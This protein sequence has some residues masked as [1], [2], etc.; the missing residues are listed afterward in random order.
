MDSVGR[1]AGGVAHETNNQMS[2]VLGAAHFLL[3]RQDLDES[4]RADLEHI[5]QA[6]DRTAQITAQLLAFSRRQLLRPVSLDLGDAVRQWENVLRR[7]AGENCRVAL[8]LAAGMGRVRVDLG[9]LHQVLLNLVLNARDAMPEGGTVTIETFETEL[10]AETTNRH[11]ST[12]IRPGPYGVIA[13]SDSGVGMSPAVLERIFEP[14]FTTKPVGAGTGLGLATVYGIVKQSEG[15]IW[16]YSEPGLGS[17]LKVYLPLESA[18]VTAE[19]PVA[20]A[21]A[22]GR[23]ELVVVIEDDEM[24]RAMTRRALEGAGY[25]VAEASGGEGGI[26]AV[27]RWGSRTGAV[28]SDLVMPGLTA[29]ALAERIEAIS[30]GTPVLFTSGY[31]DGE[32]ERRGLLPAGAPFLQKPSSP[33]A[34]VAFVGRHVRVRAGA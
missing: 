32:I 7:V 31:T 8:R 9:Q 17:T 28:L 23:G 30:P 3:R 21:P 16:A 24:V 18:P 15:Y 29:H 5:S 34:I 10:G 19:R 11:R 20:A 33:D 25:R 13:V 12:A 27:R 4:A 2:V 22:R 14:F 1:L 26:E 6:A